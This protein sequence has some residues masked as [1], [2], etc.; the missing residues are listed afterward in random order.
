MRF[1]RLPVAAISALLL[2]A[3]VLAHP[4]LLSTDPA[5]NATVAPTQRIELHF[6]EKLVPAFTGGQVAMTDMPGMRMKGPMAMTAT[7]SIGPDGTTLV[8]ALARPLPAGSYTVNWHAVASD[9]HRVE[10]SLAFRVQ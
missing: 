7:S 4:K 9:T 10:G 8:I 5:A 2:A 1:T 6:S 3:P